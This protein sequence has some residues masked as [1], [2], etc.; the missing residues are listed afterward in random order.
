MVFQEFC[1]WVATTI[2]RIGYPGIV[3][4]MA[5]ES[6]F[7]PFP[8]EIVMPPAGYQISQGEMSWTPVILAGIAGSLIGAYVNYF[9]ALWLGRPFFVR[10]GRYFLVSEASIIKAERFFQ[11][12]GEITTFVGRL[13]PMI[14]QLISLP[15]G[16]ARMNLAKFTVYTA[17]GAGIWIVVL[18]VIGYVVGE[19]KELFVRYLHDATVWTLGAVGVLVYGYV[20]WQQRKRR[21]T[22]AAGAEA[23]PPGAGAPANADGSSGGP[24]HDPR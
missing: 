23:I 16:L 20:K 2:L 10:Y 11:E 12:H 14:R 15:A 13:I 4:L 22:A 5:I 18:T 6:S 19:N 17:L 21:L 8:S 1:A 3:I 7:I 24:A 9:L